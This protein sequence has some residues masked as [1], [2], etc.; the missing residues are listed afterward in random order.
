MESRVFPPP[1]GRASARTYP[2]SMT[3]DDTPR[4]AD[5][6]IDFGKLLEGLTLEDLSA[7]GSVSLSETIAELVAEGVPIEEILGEDGGVSG[8]SSNDR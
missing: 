8:V 2:E 3:A 4:T 5:G 6:H 7:D 1:L